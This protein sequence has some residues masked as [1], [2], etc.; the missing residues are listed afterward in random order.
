MT[1]VASIQYIEKILNN[2]CNL[3]CEIPHRR[4]KVGRTFKNYEKSV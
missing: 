1:Q 3:R 2:N 4:K